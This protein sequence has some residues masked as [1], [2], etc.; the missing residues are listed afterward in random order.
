MSIPRDANGRIKRVGSGV[1]ARESKQTPGAVLLTGD[2]AATTQ[3]Y[4]RFIS[5]G[6]EYDRGYSFPFDYKPNEILFTETGDMV[7]HREIFP[8]SYQINLKSGCIYHFPVDLDPNGRPFG[9]K[10]I[11]KW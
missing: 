3:I 2:M 4:F 6:E 7:A 8:K 5:N 10:S 1:G 11:G 9:S